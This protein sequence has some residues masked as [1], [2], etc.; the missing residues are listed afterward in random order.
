MA[1]LNIV[2]NGAGGRMGTALIRA[3]LATD[4]L[5]LH[6]ALEWAG[7]DVLG[8]DAG[9]LA[10]LGPLNLP[11]E[12]DI[13]ATLVGADAILDFTTPSAS[14]ALAKEAAKNKLIHIIGTTGCTP[15][16]EAALTESAQHGAIIVK[17]GNMSLGVNLL[18]SLI[19]KAAKALGDDFDIEIVEMHH[20]QKIDAPSGTALM[21]GKAAADGRNIDLEENAVKSRDGI[22]GKR[23][24][25]TIGF[26][27]LR[28][29]TVIGDH[30]VLLAGP[31]EVIELS[32]K[33]QDRSL[34]ANGAIKALLWAQDKKPGYYSM[35][36]VLGLND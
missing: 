35:Q 7:S 26:S 6:G 18:A 12:S 3:T 36:D 30:C 31:G 23:E 8:Q 9:L 10:G 1:D 32:H 33:A 22:V 28:G 16:D 14:V 34:F 5:N 24:T 20:N 13:H 2:V 19:K 21:L 25:G 15:D 4:G 17:S 29:G 27:T 11:I